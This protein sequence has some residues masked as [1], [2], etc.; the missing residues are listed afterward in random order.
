MR[1]RFPGYYGRPEENMM[2]VSV[3]EEECADPQI[4]PFL[5]AYGGHTSVLGGTK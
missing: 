3:R 4:R 2:K 1:G 5:I